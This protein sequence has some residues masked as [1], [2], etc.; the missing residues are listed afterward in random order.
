MRKTLKLLPIASFLLASASIVSVGAYAATD[1]QLSHKAITNNDIM[2]FESL[3]Q[4]VISATG[5]LLAVEVSPDRGDS[6]GLV[7]SLTSS[8]K[9]IVK[10]G[11]KPQVSHDGRFVA[12]SIDT[13]LLEKEV[14]SSKEK[15]K[16][17]SGMALLDT[18]TG[19]E[20][21]FERVK[22]FSFNQSGT[23]LAVW[24]EPKEADKSDDKD[25]TVVDK[26]AEK[27]KKA[28]VDKFDKGSELTLVA[29][30]TGAVSYT[31][32]TLPTICSV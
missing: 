22:E 10:G 13:P 7:Q 1:A 8:K 17:K 21:R 14:A 27:E 16:L 25:N 11:S 19:K 24:F 12:F 28:K 30:N 5:K 18:Q 26:S 3:K 6:H 29:L 20:Q 32:L 4:P 15:K 2:K 9:F 31:H 23:H